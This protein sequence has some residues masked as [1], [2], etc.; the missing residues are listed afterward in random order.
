MTRTI[1][2]DQEKLQLE[3]AVAIMEGGDEVIVTRGGEK[4]A[5]LVQVKKPKAA[6]ES[7]LGTH[8]GWVSDISDDFDAEL[9]DSFWLGE[10]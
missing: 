10:E 7:L 5:L 6:R 2:L 3:D 8:P 1:D 4:V 9:P